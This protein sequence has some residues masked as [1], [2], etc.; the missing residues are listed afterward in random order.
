PEGSVESARNPLSGQCAPGLTL[1]CDIDGTPANMLVNPVDPADAGCSLLSFTLF[2]QELEVDARLIYG[3]NDEDWN[4]AVR[5]GAAIAS[6]QH[7][8][9]LA[10]SA[11]ADCDSTLPPA[12]QVTTTF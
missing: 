1:A 5:I 2:E 6:G 8:G 12:V 11:G 4:D 3:E 7:S 10:K 9:R